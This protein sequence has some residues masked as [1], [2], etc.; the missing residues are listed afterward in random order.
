MPKRTLAQDA[1]NKE[2]TVSSWTGFG[3]IPGL[4]RQFEAWLVSPF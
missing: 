4:M 1:E 2:F 3:P